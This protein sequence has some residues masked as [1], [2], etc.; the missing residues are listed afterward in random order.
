MKRLS[1]SNLDCKEEIM[2][3]SP[4]SKICFSILVH[5][6]KELVKQLI[7]NVRYHCPNSAIVLYNG[8]NEPTLCDGLGVP[9]YP[10]S[11]KLNRG[12]TTIYFLETMEWLEEMGI[13][14]EYYINLD[15]D[16]LFFRKG[17]EEFIQSEMKDT[18]YMAV[19]LRTPEPNWF[20]GRELRKD[21]HSWG[22]LFNVNNFLGIFNVG[23]IISR[24]LVKELLEPER[25]KLIKKILAETPTWGSDEILFVNMAKD[26]GFR[27]KSYP[28]NVGYSTI[29]FRPH[30][31]LNEMLSRLN[32]I[33][34]GWLCH[35]IV[36]N[37]N[38]LARKLIIHKDSEHFSKQY[39]SKEYPWYQNDSNNYAISFP[40]KSHF[41]NLELIVQSD[42]SLTHYWQDPSGK[43]NKSGTFAEGVTG[44]PL[45]YENNAGNYTVVSKLRTRGVGFWVRDNSA[46]RYPW[47]GPSIIIDEDVNPIMLDQLIDGRY[48]LVC[49]SSNQYYYWAQENKWAKDPYIDV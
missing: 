13:D 6:D 48:I 16:V 35:P 30:F 24:P 41:G 26:L 19:N 42:A 32:H 43:W 39:K 29:R 25:N 28:Y 10:S 36:R 11:R 3:E 20:V 12:W 4:K 49:E 37:K 18:D 40:I 27:L 2:M 23:Q 31:S 46:T 45:F 14:Y 21:I 8:G 17:Y 5:D 34:T 1:K 44:I 47:Y 33:Q 22:K 15:S 7:E 9:V 38:N